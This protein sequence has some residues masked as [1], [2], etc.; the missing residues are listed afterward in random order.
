MVRTWAVGLGAT[1]QDQ[2]GQ[3]EGKVLT[4]RTHGQLQRTPAQ[5]EGRGSKELSIWDMKILMVY[6]LTADLTGSSLTLGTISGHVCEG[7]LG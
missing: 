3:R 5:R 6:I 1:N 2:G 7:F 4:Q